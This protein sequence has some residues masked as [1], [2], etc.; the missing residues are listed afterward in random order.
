MISPLQSTSRSL[1]F[2]RWAVG[3]LFL[4][5]MPLLAVAQQFEKVYEINADDASQLWRPA[6][7]LDY[8]PSA[9]L[10]LGGDGFLYGVTDFDSY[11]TVFKIATSGAVTT[12]VQFGSFDDEP[13]I[14]ASFGSAPRGALLRGGDGYFYGTTEWGGE[15]H[16]GNVFRVSSS[17]EFRK[18]VDFTGSNEEDD[19]A[20]GSNPQAELIFGADG[21]LYGTTYDGGKWNSGVVFKISPSGIMSTLVDFS[22]DEGPAPG[23]HPSA[24]LVQA[25]D[26]YFYGVTQSGGSG[27]NGTIFKM[28]AAGA[29]VTLVEFT[30]QGG[31]YK[32]SGP[33]ATLT[34][35]K[36]G[37]L[38]GTTSGGG[39]HG[40]GTV[41]RATTQGPLSP[42]LNSLH[43]K[44]TI[45][46][47]IR[48]RN[49]WR[50][51]TAIS[52]APRQRRF[53]RSRKMVS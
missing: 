22:G 36:D 35:G 32:G 49:S 7:A 45:W 1:A 38:Y 16:D 28:S 34:L 29:L 30:G 39:E 14:A 6:Y 31:A 12:L 51:A 20:R 52:S 24:G 11:G 43:P 25:P 27:G 50:M 4:A 13:E 18:L 10:V 3:V 53:S 46:D 37:N 42:C 40:L 48:R 5:L 33:S 44:E 19:Q 41:F 26:G 17:G 2:L 21:Y 9:E 23:A 15:H 47:P 8:Y